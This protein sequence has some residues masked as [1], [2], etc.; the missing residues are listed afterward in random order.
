MIINFKDCEIRCSLK[1]YMIINLCSLKAYM[2]INFKDCEISRE[3][4][5]L[6]I[7]VNNNNNNKLYL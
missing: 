2:I 6:D 7:Y 1:A 3:V 4:R 5:K